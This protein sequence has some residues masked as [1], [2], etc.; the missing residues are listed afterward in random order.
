MSKFLEERKEN[1]IPTKDIVVLYHGDC[2]DGFGGA[3]AA[4]KKFGDTAD[5]IPV[6]HQHKPP[7]GLVDK[8]IYMIDFTYPEPLLREMI[9]K[10]KRV[11]AMDH[12]ES[13]KQVTMMTQG[14]IYDVNH[15][16]SVLAWKHFHLGTDIPLILKYIEDYDLWRHEMPDTKEIFAYLDLYDFNFETWSKLAEEIEDEEKFKEIVEKGKF[17]LQ[18]QNKLINRIVNRN[19]E[20]VEFEGIKTYAINSPDFRSEVGAMTVEAL[21][22]IA[23]I[24]YQR[25]NEIMISLKSDG[26]VDVSQLA[27]KYDGGGHLAS[28]GF[29]LSID[30][31]LPWKDLSNE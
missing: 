25:K 4:W 31:P 24:W 3:W 21:P 2:S 5:Y 12:H 7:E 13:N 16:G 10:N 18:Y 9:E 1:R 30:K 17:I 27:K 29:I 19:A 26:T 22:P 11:T 20:V 23:I 15:S 14:G 8:E 28:A 6:F